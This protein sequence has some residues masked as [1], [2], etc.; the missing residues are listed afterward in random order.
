MFFFGSLV[1]LQM[2]LNGVEFSTRKNYIPAGVWQ[3][4]NN[5]D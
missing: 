2:K 5:E 1:K 3:A 4:H